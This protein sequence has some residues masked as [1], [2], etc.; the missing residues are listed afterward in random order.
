[1]SA[2]LIGIIGATIALGGL[3]S[4]LAGFMFVSLN[5]MERRLNRQMEEQKNDLI[6]QMG[7]QKDDLIRQMGEQKNDLVKQI[8]DL[9]RDHGRRLDSID[10]RLRRVEQGQSEVKGSVET[11]RQVVIATLQR[12]I[13]AESAPV[14]AD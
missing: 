14:G 11:L 1:M 12:E 4:T 9:K 5:R 8:D 7:E 10:D 3:I 6:R 13:E 2:E